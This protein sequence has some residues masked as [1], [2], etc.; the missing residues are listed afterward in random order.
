MSAV[1][2]ASVSYMYRLSAHRGGRRQL[3]GHVAQVPREAVGCLYRFATRSARRSWGRGFV[4]CDH[5]FSV[6]ASGLGGVRHRNGQDLESRT[7]FDQVKSRNSTIS[8]NRLD[9]R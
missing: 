7:A 1:V 9:N 3:D 4:Q 6:G 5:T 8:G 2:K